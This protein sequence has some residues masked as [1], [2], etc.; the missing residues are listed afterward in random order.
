MPGGST[1]VRRVTRSITAQLTLRLDRLRNLHSVGVSLS[2][3][4]KEGFKSK[5]EI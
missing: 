2:Y 5:C 3:L 1:E 4:S